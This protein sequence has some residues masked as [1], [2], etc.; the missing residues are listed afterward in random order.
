MSILDT[1]CTRRFMRF[2]NDA[3]SQ[4]W[5]E[6]NGGNLSY[7]L[8]DADIASCA[9]SFSAQGTWNELTRAVS[10]L[11]GSR[12]MVTGSGKYLH[13]A[14]L[15]PTSTFGIVEIDAHG[16]A[17]RT[18]WGLEGARPSSELETHLAVYEN[19][20]DTRVVYHAHCPNVIALSTVF[21]PETRVW[22]RALWQSMTECIIVFPQGL[23]AMPWKVPG[24]PELADETCELMKTHKVCVWAQHGL[25][26]RARDFDEAFGLAHTVEKSAGIYLQAC[27]A[28]GGEKPRFLVSD[29]QLRA[30]ARRY[31]IVADESFLD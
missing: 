9:G 16:T 18:V 21:P 2:C 24:S 1:D 8:N 11:A 30:V 6:A 13:N 29:E 15:E 3:F 26:A 22:T 4:G 17:W 7:R 28:S 19:G 12:I 20:E 5:H 27:A 23:A 31:A 10:A 14:E 25:I